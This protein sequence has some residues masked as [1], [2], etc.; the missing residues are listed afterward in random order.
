MQDWIIFDQTKLD[1]EYEG[2]YS[3]LLDMI[4]T[5]G[6]KNYGYSEFQKERPPNLSAF[7]LD[8]RTINAQV[9]SVDSYQFEI[10]INAALPCIIN[11]YF[12][13][14]FRTS[15]FLPHIGNPKNET[16]YRIFNGAFP[17]ALPD[18]LSLYQAIPEITNLSRPIQDERAYAA[19]LFSNIAFSFCLYH[20]V[21]H[22]ELGHAN[23]T[24]SLFGEERIVEFFNKLKTVVNWNRRESRIRRVWEFEADNYALL[25]VLWDC[26]NEQNENV[27]KKGLGISPKND[28]YDFIGCIISAIY[29]VFHIYGSSQRGKTHSSY[30]PHPLVRFGSIYSQLLQFCETFFKDQIPDE[31]RL[32]DVAFSAILAT[33]RSWEEM[34]LKAFD[35]NKHK[36]WDWIFKQVNKLEKDRLMFFK[37]YVHNSWYYPFSR[38]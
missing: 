38:E 32:S 20:E 34:K 6:H 33:H 14:I 37:E 29:A 25:M 35:I 17:T 11:F 18:N 23:S 2:Y 8:K 36:N 30:H 19:L 31:E 1:D 28:T 24:L 4:E 26:L 3:S 10:A 7:F 9:L 5:S 27:F 12:N 16:L 15:T 22:I 21:A 13:N